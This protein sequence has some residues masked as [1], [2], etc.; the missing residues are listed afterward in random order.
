MEYAFEQGAGEIYADGALLGW[1]RRS[2]RSDLSPARLSHSERIAYR[3][4]RQPGNRRIA[5]AHCHGALRGIHSYHGYARSVRDLRH[6][7]IRE[8]VFG[9]VDTAS[10]AMVSR[11]KVRQVHKY[12]Y[13]IDLRL[14]SRSVQYL[15]TNN[16]AQAWPTEVGFH[17]LPG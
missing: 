15:L 14:T 9:Y 4:L 3:A 8:V 6:E 16:M 7:V 17:V 10:W 13:P 2:G 5:E 11:L 1:R 12:D